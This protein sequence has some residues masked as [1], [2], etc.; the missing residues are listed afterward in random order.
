MKLFGKKTDPVIGLDI[1]STSVRLL[2]LSRRGSGY[3]IDHF[4]IEPLGEGVVVD[5][6]VQDVEAISNAISRAVRASGTRA[7]NCA[8]AVSGSA[9]FTKTISLPADLAEADIESQVQIEA[10]QYIPYPLDEVSL[11]FEVLGPSPR[12]VDLMDILLAAS[13]SENVESRQD[14]IDSAGLKAKVVDVEA[15]AIANAFE[16]I[17]NRDGVN[18]NDAVGF[19]DIG[20]DLTTLLVIKGGRVI[21][22]RDHPFGG[23]QLQEEIQRRYDMTAEQ[24]AFFERNEEAPQDFEE[25]V[26]EPFQLNIVHQISRALQFYASSNEYS[27]ISTIYLS[28][29]G[30]SLKG[31]APM[32]QQELGMT[33]RVADPV[34]GLDLAQNVAVTVLKRNANNLMIAMGLALR[35]FD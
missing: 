17:R 5:K 2:Q 23:H 1:G 30:A 19:F 31:L 25:E 22:T 13:K 4:A 29:G 32:V 18:R 26:L 12:N 8:I 33:T 14:A 21:Y 9:V 15:F 6:A 34:T 20:Y 10:N 24:A 11:D 27:N 3:R 7:K 16:L 35:G 28:G